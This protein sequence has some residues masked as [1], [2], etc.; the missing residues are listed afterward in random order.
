MAKFMSVELGDI[1]ALR[2]KHIVVMPDSIKDTVV[3]WY[4]EQQAIS[5]YDSVDME[6]RGKEPYHGE[7]KITKE[8]AR[9][10]DCDFDYIDEF[11]ELIPLEEFVKTYGDPWK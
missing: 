4:L 9:N 5:Y 1:Y 3:N 11:G 10:S 8:E 2:T 6:E 7:E